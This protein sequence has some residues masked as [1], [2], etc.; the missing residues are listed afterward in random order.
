MAFNKINKNI[1]QALFEAKVANKAT[2]YKIE[3][4]DFVSGSKSLVVKNA[5]E[6]IGKVTDILKRKEN[7]PHS[8]YTVKDY[9]DQYYI[10]GLTHLDISVYAYTLISNPEKVM[11]LMFDLWDN[12]YNKNGVVQTNST[13]IDGRP[14]EVTKQFR[15]LL[16]KSNIGKELPKLYKKIVSYIKTIKTPEYAYNKY[17]KTKSSTTKNIFK[18]EKAETS[19]FFA[20]EDR[21][22]ADIVMPWRYYKLHL[23]VEP[24]IKSTDTIRIYGYIGGLG[25]RPI[26]DYVD[27]SDYNEAIDYIKTMIKK[28][29]EYDQKEFEKLNKLAKDFDDQY[30]PYIDNAPKF[31]FDGKNEIIEN[32]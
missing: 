5:K 9:I 3:L 13:D 20:R 25:E 18:Y 32:S 23:E 8:N 6:F 12:Y 24:G 22:T 26:E 30:T 19:I 21:F 11:P 17:T 28:T 7:N 31:K 14:W 10:D 16:G 29:V 2:T 1:I 4:P 27:I 15:E